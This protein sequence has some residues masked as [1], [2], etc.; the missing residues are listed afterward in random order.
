MVVAFLALLA[1]LVL[2]LVRGTWTWFALAA[3]VFVILRLLLTVAIHYENPLP[4]GIDTF[5]DLAGLL[6]DRR[7]PELPVDARKS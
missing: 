2:S 7:Q 1:G 6:A 3:A 4:S 5:G